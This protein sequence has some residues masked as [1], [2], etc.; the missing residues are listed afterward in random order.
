[1]TTALEVITD[2]YLDLGVLADGETASAEQGAFGLRKLNQMT[3]AWELDGIAI[4]A[5]NWSLTT[6]IPLPANH[7]QA[8]I[9]NLA[10]RLAPSFGLGAV[11]SPQ[12]AKLAD[13]GYRALQAAYGDPLDMTVDPLISGRRSRDMEWR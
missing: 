1:M 11:V 2:A 13:D 4:G 12:T 8:I 6:D 10:M 7:I 5:S 3:A 9:A